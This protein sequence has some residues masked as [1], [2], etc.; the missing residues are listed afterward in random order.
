MK[1]LFLVLG[2]LG[3]IAIGCTK[4][5][6]DKGNDNN[7]NKTE[8]PGENGGGSEDGIPE[9]IFFGLDKE[10]VTISPDGGSVDVIVYSNYKWE[11]SGASDWCTPS[12]T[13]GEPNEDG[14]KV[15]FSADVA[16]DDRE[17][18]FW[19]RCADEKI[20]FVVSQKFKAV[21]IPDANNHFTIPAEGGI[22]EI[23]YRTTVDCEVIIPEEAKDWI[24]VV[25]ATRGLVNENINLDIAENTTYDPRGAVI[26]VIAKDNADL[27]V[28]YTIYQ[29]QKD[30]I[31][32]DENNSFIVTAK[33][34]NVVI[35]YQTNVDCEVI[36]PVEAQ[37]WITVAPATKGL[38]THSTTLNI[39]E[40]KTD[41]QRQA[42]VKVVSTNNRELFAEYII[43]QNPRYYI[44]YTSTNGQIVKPYNTSAF[45][46][47]ILSNTYENGVG[48]IEFYSNVT[49]IGNNAF[50]NCS[51]LKSI[52]I[53]NSVTSIGN[54]AFYGCTGELIINSKI[55]ETNYT[56]SKYP[57]NNGWLS[58]AKFTS[59]IIGDSITSIGNYAFSEC[60]SLINVTIGDSITSIGEYAFSECSSLINATIGDRV[61]SIGDCAF[62]KC[63]SLTKFNGN[64]A[65]KDGRCLIINGRLE[66]FAPAGLNEYTIPD[67]ITT[68][69]SVAFYG[70]SKLTRVTIPDSVTTIGGASFSNC[71]NLTHVTIPDSVTTIGGAA[72]YKCSSLTSVIIPDRVTEIGYNTFY[73][74]SNL[75]LVIIPDSVT[76]IGGASFSNCS[77]LTHVT[78]PDNVTEIG[79]Y[80]FSGCG[81]LTSITIPDRVTWIGQEAFSG[82]KGDL[83][84][85]SKIIEKNYTFSNTPSW[86]DGAKFTKLTIGNSVNTIGDYAFYRK[87]ILTSVTIPDNVTSIGSNAFYGCSSLKSV[88][89]GKGIT[90]IGSEAFYGCT[91]NLFIN[92]NIPSSIGP[93]DGAFYGSD[94]SSVTIGEDVTSIG[95][96][97]F[98]GCSSLKSVYISDI[99][100]WCNLSFGKVNYN[101]SYSLYLNNELVTDLTIPNSVTE[102]KYSAFEGCSS[103]KSV[104]IPDSVTTIGNLAFKGCSSLKS[105]TIP[106]SVTK[107]QNAVF[108]DC[109]SL[110]S[111]TIPNSVTEIEGS[112]FSGCSSLESVTIPN[113]VTTIKDYAFFR[114][115]H[116]ENV[117]CKAI[118]PPSL[119]SHV[120]YYD[121]WGGDKKIYCDIYVPTES[122]DAYKSASGWSEYASDIVGYD[123]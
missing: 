45:G 33:G 89:I 21:I 52:T 27:V 58:G 118:T 114:C 43:I 106:N 93:S 94:F 78:I 67:N 37:D 8:Q 15:T 116:L 55:V 71:S 59:I 4:D 30:A 91:G 109:S 120:F 22:A 90:S 74:C 3:V 19:F 66:S 108:S 42:T 81:K 56:S 48:I 64:L 46:A 16:Y 54:N 62:Y 14:Q 75:V 13:K 12:I 72:F 18:T 123:F 79:A 9:N 24:T 96:S 95:L 92:G 110:T 63:S 70:C 53:P 82:C 29:A 105:V 7:N 36:I 122:V 39:V 102:I 69:G 73:G 87:S 103:L 97:A 77:N 60:S 117:Y 119:G 98:Y 34:G 99:A 49:T 68:I 5:E 61:I 51:K 44:E 10:S 85:N 84:I 6:V 11:I 41:E 25:P 50:K 104:T 65:S 1:K 80:A 101:S 38:T 28:E 32:A 113:S 100:A 35:D 115:T 107:I 2:I 47:S 83:F 112:A 31:L 86:L 121:D 23:S 57:S 88:T 76:T 17:A 111:I 20:K 40:N 26:K